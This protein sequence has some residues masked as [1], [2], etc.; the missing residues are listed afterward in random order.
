MR[1]RLPMH[2]SQR[3]IRAR[4]GPARP[5][6]RRSARA[7]ATWCCASCPRFNDLDDVVAGT[8]TIPVLLSLPD[9][10]LPPVLQSTQW[11]DLRFHWPKPG[12]PEL[13]VLA[14]WLDEP[15]EVMKRLGVVPS[16]RAFVLPDDVRRLHD[17]LVVSVTSLVMAG[18]IGAEDSPGPWIAALAAAVI[19][20]RAILL[21]RTR[22]PTPRFDWYLPAMAVLA[23]VAAVALIGTPL[24]SLLAVLPL[25]VVWLTS[26]RPIA[27]WVPR[28]PDPTATHR[29]AQERL[30][31]T[32]RTF[33]TAVHIAAL[34]AVGRTF[35]KERR[36]RRHR[37]GARRP[38]LV[39]R[40]SGRAVIGTAVEVSDEADVVSPDASPP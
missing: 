15:G 3:G 1:D 33:G 30:L 21:I 5:E 17:G 18:L 35:R 16:Y 25:A 10:D 19:G 22:T 40:M 7:L 23:V 31:R 36:E 12:S 29:T 27:L 6:H 13:S 34:D 9:D 26:R 38:A 4:G 32:L 11:L 14:R 24:L 28:V 39:R 37:P 8:R 20:V 2:W